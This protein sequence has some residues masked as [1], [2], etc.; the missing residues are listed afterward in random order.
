LECLRRSRRTLGECFRRSRRTL[1]VP[2][3]IPKDPWRVLSADPEGP[4]E[5]LRGSRRTLGE[6]FRRSRRTLGVPPQI[7]KDP[8]SDPVNPEG[9]SEHERTP[10]NSRRLRR[11]TSVLPTRRPSGRPSGPKPGWRAPQPKLWNAR[12]RHFCDDLPEGRSLQRS[13][14][15]RGF[16]PGGDRTERLRIGDSRLCTVEPRRNA[17]RLPS[18]RGRPPRHQ[19]PEGS[20]FRG[21]DRA[22]RP[23]L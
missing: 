16:R 2:P 14:T 12:P 22:V 21:R 6:C 7:P 10:C 23:A 19:N 11:A 17:A 4:L 3:Q 1:G 13:V 20:W 18:P 8:W 15:P 5:C 9:L